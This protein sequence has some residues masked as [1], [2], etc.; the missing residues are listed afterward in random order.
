MNYLNSMYSTNV[1]K[2]LRRIRVYFPCQRAP[3]LFL[4]PGNIVL[5]ASSNP[6]PPIVKSV[7]AG[8]ERPVRAEPKVSV[9]NCNGTSR[10]EKRVDNEFGARV[11][12]T[13]KTKHIKLF[14]SR[15][16]SALKTPPLASLRSTPV[17]L[18]TVPVFPPMLESGQ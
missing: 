1:I 3:P 5:I 9:I 13:S 17:K 6:C 4:A 15:S 16:V 11:L 8:Q 10:T 7:K 2:S 14:P 18:F 12:T